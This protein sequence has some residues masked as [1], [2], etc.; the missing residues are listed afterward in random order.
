MNVSS[1]ISFIVKI[2]GFFKS[3]LWKN[4][5]IVYING[6]VKNL[7]V[8]EIRKLIVPS[9][10]KYINC[11]SNK[12]NSISYYKNH[13][14]KQKINLYQILRNCRDSSKITYCGFSS[15]MFSVF[16]GYV[17]GD[18]LNYNF[19]E[20]KP[21]NDY[22]LFSEKKEFVKQD[23]KIDDSTKEINLIIETSYKIDAN[24]ILNNPIIKF[25]E[26]EPAE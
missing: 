4:K 6:N 15:Q 24:K 22:Y 1:W 3:I 9:D 17:L 2:C 7:N 11:Q 18:T 13:F 10:S 19:I 14:L 8:E 12:K 21:N 20:L 5:N 16:D 23:V 26:Q 25:D